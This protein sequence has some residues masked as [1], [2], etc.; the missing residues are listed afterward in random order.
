MQTV[1][2]EERDVV[3]LQLVTG[4]TA[5]LVAVVRLDISNHGNGLVIVVSVRVEQEYLVS[6]SQ[7]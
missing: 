1:C 7:T 2:L 4:I 6:C 5:S 3:Y